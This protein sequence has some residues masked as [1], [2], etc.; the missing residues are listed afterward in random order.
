LLKILTNS[1]SF[2][3]ARLLRNPLQDLL[4]KKVAVT[5]DP[6]KI[7]SYP[8]IRYGNSYPVNISEETD[9][10]S[11]NFIKFSSNKLKFSGIMERNKIYSPIYKRSLGELVFPLLIRETLTSFGC[12][13]IHVI[14]NQEEFDSIW[15]NRFYWTKYINLSF[16]LRIH[17]LGNEITRI[18]KKKLNE[19]QEFPIRNNSLCHFSLKIP[20]KYPKLFEFIKNLTS[21]EE[22]NNGKFYSI[23][24]GWDTI[25]KK[26]FVI[27]L[28]TG[29]GLN[30][31]TA[32]N[33]ADYIYQN[34]LGE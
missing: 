33:Y 17:I 25:N 13:G 4:R 15:N 12:K 20:G 23:D 30:E 2:P 5:S 28:N 6:N 32:E 34:L 14:K 24:I 22:V 11:P 1:S 7:N 10:N 8:F 3:S 18:F 21:V 27:E 29:S 19:P 31:N 9:Y 26:Y 16:E